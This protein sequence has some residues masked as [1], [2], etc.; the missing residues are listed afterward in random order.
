MKMD[1]KINARKTMKHRLCNFILG[2]LLLWLPLQGFAATGMT[3]CRHDHSPPPAHAGMHDHHGV[4]DGHDC[5]H[6]QDS[7]PA[8]P[9]TQC[10][11]CG[12]CHIC[13]APALLPV[14]A[15]LNSGAG[16]SFKFAFDTH[17]PLFFPEQPQRPPRTFFS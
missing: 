7:S 13:G 1:K 16:F 10:D 15:G 14:P 8:S 5:S 17:F 11:D 4:H 12:Y 3:F 6:G 2:F 9:Q